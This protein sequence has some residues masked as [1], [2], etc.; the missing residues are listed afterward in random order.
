[1]RNVR[2]TPVYSGVLAVRELEADKPEKEDE[3]SA[4]HQGLQNVNGLIESH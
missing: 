1:M 2:A 3:D 4:D